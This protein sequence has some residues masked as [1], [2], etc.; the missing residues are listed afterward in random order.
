MFKSIAL[1]SFTFLMLVS[2]GSEKKPSEGGSFSDQAEEIES[3]SNLS[4]ACEKDLKKYS[5]F[6]D[7]AREYAK[8]QNEGHDFTEAEEDEWKKKTN[9]LMKELATSAT[10]YTDVNCIMAFQE[11]Q[12]EF[13]KVMMEMAKANM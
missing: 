4:A 2:C 11:V 7:E 6:L 13:T 10:A 5:S 3:N 12:M 8:K 1:F 9:E